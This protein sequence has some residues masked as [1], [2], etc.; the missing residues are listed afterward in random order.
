MSCG[1]GTSNFRLLDAFVGWD[2][3]DI[4]NLI[5]QNAPE[6][7]QLAKEDPNALDPSEVLT[8]IPPAHLARGCGPCDWYLVTPAPPASRLLSR[9]ACTGQWLSLWCPGCDSSLLVKAVAVAAR[10]RRVAVA[11]TGTNTVWIWADGGQRLA[12][13]IKIDDPGPIA[14]T[15]WGD[16][17]VTSKRSTTV[18]RFGPA[19]ES[20]GGIP[21]RLPDTVDRIAVSDDGTIWVVTRT[22]SG[23]LHVWHASREDTAFHPAEL[24]ALAKAFRPTDLVAESE[25]GFC[26]EERGSDGIPST[27]CF[28]WN[29]SSIDET[30]IE[31]PGPPKLYVQGQLLTKPIDSGIPRCGW[32]RVR[33]DADVPTGTTLAVA[34]ATSET[35]EPPDQGDPNI[36]PVWKDF[37]AGKPHPRDWQLAPKGSQDFLID[38]PPGRYLFLR[39]R[40]TGDGKATPTV[41]RLRIDFPRATSADFLPPV[42]RENPQA[43]DF[44]ERFLSLFDASIAD[45]DRAI[46][47]YPALLDPSGVPDEL[48]PWLGSFLDV[49]FDPV[50]EPERRRAILRAVPALYRRRGTVAG[51]VETIRTV[52]DVEPAIQELERE[53]N[54]RGLGRGSY[55]RGV[56]LFGKA[57]ARFRLGSSSLSIAPLKSYGSPDDDPLGT[58][59]YRFRVLVPPNP[60]V[61]GAGRARLER[62]VASQKPAHTIATVRVGGQGLILGNSSAVGVDTV[63]TRLPA[64]VLG[65]GGNIRLRRMSILWSG[66]R[67]VSSGIGVGG[68]AAV[69]I[70]TVME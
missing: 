43:D 30:E 22:T 10:G 6:G 66:R 65:Q 7:V 49:A 3:F 53:R 38:Q 26:L 55:L 70:H 28:S 16:L 69:G 50:W 32:H 47:R 12:A 25:K 8:R 64:P 40:L 23:S 45:L 36:D 1:P 24:T 13:A 11:D 61:S 54:W 20:R 31:R 19:G 59:A 29:G 21:A 33:V 62:L 57:Q 9:D 58:H 15:P 34:V 67:A 5:G 39:L 52:F 14:F 51:L 48:L 41:R 18:W 68:G 27:Q 4:K 2:E 56:R 42:Y 17:L 37:L 35:S 63:F 44:T 46:E 60:L